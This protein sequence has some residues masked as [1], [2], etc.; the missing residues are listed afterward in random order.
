MRS[1]RVSTLDEISDFDAATMAEHALNYQWAL[2]NSRATNLNPV[3]YPPRFG[4]RCFD[5]LIPGVFSSRPREEPMLHPEIGHVLKAGLLTL[6][7]SARPSALLAQAPPVA[8]AQTKTEIV[9]QART[10]PL[11]SNR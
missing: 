3:G 6:A 8:V 10:T 7:L 4:V 11:V 1:L 9:N 2:D 5:Q